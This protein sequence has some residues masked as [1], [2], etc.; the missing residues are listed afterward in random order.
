MKTV[1]DAGMWDPAG[2]WDTMALTQQVSLHHAI[3]TVGKIL[4]YCSARSSNSLSLIVE[5]KACTVSP[6]SV[7]LLLIVLK[8]TPITSATLE[9]L[10]PIY[11]V[12][13]Q[14][15]CSLVIHNLG[16][17]LPFPEDSCGT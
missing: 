14:S 16:R 17:P 15:Q 11:A 3:S 5:Y 1:P 7:I 6:Y 9:Q 13:I 12:G 10:N 2:M 8:L 4:F